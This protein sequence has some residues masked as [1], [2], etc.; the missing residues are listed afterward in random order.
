MK[1]YIIPEDV[2]KALIAYLS[3]RPYKEVA[4]GLAALDRL[5]ELKEKDEDNVD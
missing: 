5:Q 1:K 4:N 2:L 3:D